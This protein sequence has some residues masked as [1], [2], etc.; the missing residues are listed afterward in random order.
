MHFPAG[1]FAYKNIMAST[2][3]HFY[4]FWSNENFLLTHVGVSLLQDP[5]VGCFGWLLYLARKSGHL[6]AEAAERKGRV[7]N[8]QS[9]F[10]QWEL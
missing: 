8:S 9:C 3:D 5:D 10:H 1:R 2:I 6:G 7:D 4:R